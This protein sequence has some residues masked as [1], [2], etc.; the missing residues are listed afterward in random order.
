MDPCQSQCN[1]YAYR[2]CISARSGLKGPTYLGRRWEN[3]KG[4]FLGLRFLLPRCRSLGA[5]GK[6]EA[7]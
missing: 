3:L 4:K 5:I 1:L 7:R 2:A 6:L